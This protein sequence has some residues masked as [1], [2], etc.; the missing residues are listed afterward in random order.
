M[1]VLMEK[2]PP[3]STVLGALDL[4]G[5]ATAREA[6][7]HTV[8]AVRRTMP[9]RSGRARRAQ[10]GRVTREG[11]GFRVE[12]KPRNT[13]QYPGGVTPVQVTRFIDQGTG[14]YGPRGRPYG[15]RRAE[16]FRLPSGW[17]SGTIQGQKAQHIYDRVERS[18]EAQVFRIFERGSHRAARRMEAALDG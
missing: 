18:E 9:A 1:P 4:E 15:P 6:S 7:Q 2:L 10:A 14:V 8:S 13:S 5:Q 17:H 12:V 16:A 11:Q 3:I